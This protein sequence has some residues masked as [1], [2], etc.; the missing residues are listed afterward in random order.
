VLNFAICPF[1]KVARFPD[2]LERHKQDRKCLVCNIPIKLLNYCGG[3]RG[4][5]GRCY[6][7][8]RLEGDRQKF[9]CRL[10]ANRKKFDLLTPLTRES[11][12]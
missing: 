8:E 12:E 2:L 1:C 3:A 7:V 4:L 9:P 6:V 5:C 11:E 10:K